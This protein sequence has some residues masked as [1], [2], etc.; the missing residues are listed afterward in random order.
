MTTRPTDPRGASRRGSTDAGDL[1]YTVA[2]GATPAR[3]KRWPTPSDIRGINA[4]M[5]QR[6]RTGRCVVC[7]K[8]AGD[9]AGAT[10]KATNCIRCWVLG[11]EEPFTVTH[12]RMEY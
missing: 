5:R 7:G 1:G 8:P 10:C 9:M 12:E 3:G 2:N 4:A 6:E 11:Y